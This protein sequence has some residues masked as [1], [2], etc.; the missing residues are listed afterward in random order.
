MPESKRQSKYRFTLKSLNPQLID[1]KY[2][3][4][5]EIET[6][7]KISDLD[8][9]Q[10]K[11]TMVFMGPTKQLHKCNVSMIDHSTKTKL[12]NDYNCFW[13]RNSF[14]N[15]SI[16]CPLSHVPDTTEYSYTSV[17]N[18]N[19]Y[20]IKEE[21]DTKSNSYITDGAFCSFNC[22]MAY[23]DENKKDTLYRYSKQLLL[24]M[25]NDMFDTKTTSI[26]KAPHWR[27]LNEYGGNLSI[28]D[29]R[30]S[31]D[32]IEYHEHGKIRMACEGHLYEK[33]LKF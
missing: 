8:T 7:T 30:S 15:L 31:F 29:F 19:I 18:S 21:T 33:K 22:C 23:I 10:T 12:N 27:M 32:R 20:K 17:I 11:K 16:G 13:C 6:T 28:D 5:S 24:K 14:D 3:I 26:S 4:T 1:D 9:S 25:Y 2:G